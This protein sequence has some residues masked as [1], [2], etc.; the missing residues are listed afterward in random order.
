[1]KTHDVAIVGLGIIGSAIAYQL[2][3]RNLD[4]LALERFW[5]L[6][7]QSSSHGHT[8]LFRQAHFEHPDYVP[9]ARRAYESWRELEQLCDRQL[10][11]STGAL[12]IGSATGNIVSG[13][14]ISADDHRIPYEMLRRQELRERFPWLKVGATDVGLLEKSAGILLAQDSVAAFQSAAVRAGA[15]LRFGAKC[16]L[17]VSASGRTELTANGTA[18]PAKRVVIATGPWTSQ[19]LPADW[20]PP[21]TVERA[22]SFWFQPKL[23]AS[24]FNPNEFPVVLRDHPQRPLIIFPSTSARGIKVAFHHNGQPINPEELD[25]VAST[26][27]VTAARSQLEVAA[28]TLAGELTASSACMYTTTRDGHFAIGYVGGNDRVLL[29][30]ACSGHGFKF[31]PVVAD[32]AADLLIHGSARHSATLFR[33]DRDTLYP[34]SQIAEIAGTGRPVKRRQASRSRGRPSG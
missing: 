29:V 13:T 30:S 8:R 22:L 4:V 27:E 2:A 21:L 15:E 16:E 31:A 10:F 17:H 3:R 32:I 26:Q 33:L 23:T 6:H 18:I 9:L 24:D 34:R 5:S 11:L 1:M 14:R 25:R 7:D 12:M 19:V 20:I 28:P